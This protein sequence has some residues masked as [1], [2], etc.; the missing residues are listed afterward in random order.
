MSNRCT[1]RANVVS[2]SKS[3]DQ[4]FLTDFGSPP[5][6]IIALWTTKGDFRDISLF[7][8]DKTKKREHLA[9][10]S[11]CRLGNTRPL[12]GHISIGSINTRKNLHPGVSP[13]TTESNKGGSVP[14]IW[15]NQA[16]RLPEVHPDYNATASGR[17]SNGKI[18]KD[19]RTVKIVT[20]PD[21]SLCKSYSTVA[22]A[23]PFS[24]SS[25]NNKS[26]VDDGLDHSN[27]LQPSRLM[28]WHEATWNDLPRIFHPSPVRLDA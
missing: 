20:C 13:P 11:M 2:I 3:P 14:V 24:G 22:L 4:S 8:K 10:L 12:P 6:P 16:R 25:T 1:S 23:S 9:T 17:G 28:V 5:I 19:Q 26:W 21:L 15:Q 18:A 27:A 7:A